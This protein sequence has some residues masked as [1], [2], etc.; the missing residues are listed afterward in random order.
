MWVGT[1]DGREGMPGQAAHAQ[2][3]GAK[4]ASVA[5]FVEVTGLESPI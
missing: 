1:V 4:S 3:A 5:P 2:V